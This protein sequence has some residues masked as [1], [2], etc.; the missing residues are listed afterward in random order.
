MIDQ[1]PSLPAIPAWTSLVLMLLVV[2]M[3]AGLTAFYYPCGDD[4]HY[5]DLIT[6]RSF[7]QGQRIMYNTWSGR[8]TATAMVTAATAWEFR[9]TKIWLA[10]NFVVY[11]LAM[12]YLIST[13]TGRYLR[14]LEVWLLATSL[15]VIHL[16]TMCAPFEGFY[17]LTSVFVYEFGA[18]LAMFLLATL[19]RPWPGNRWPRLG[20]FILCAVIGLVVAGTGE[21]VA[22]TLAIFLIAGLVWFA[23][24]RDMR[25][26]LWLVTLV[27]FAIGFTISCLAPGNDVRQTWFK[28]AHQFIPSVKGSFRIVFI[29][30]LNWFRQP[31]VIVATLLWLLVIW[32]G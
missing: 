28:Q 26:W 9:F 31:L 13:V 15:M 19:P 14:R 2:A 17:W 10:L 32:R 5:A 21:P 6:G 23:M 24:R 11:L 4:W 1:R 8:F 3:F 25:C 7:L 29:L 27:F 18:A 30:M 16:T 12:C 20:Q 22:L